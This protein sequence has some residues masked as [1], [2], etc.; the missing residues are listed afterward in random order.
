MGEQQVTPI[1]GNKDLVDG[2]LTIRYGFPDQGEKT[3]TFGPSNVSI[4]I[5]RSGAIR[6]QIPLLVGANDDLKVTAQE[7]QL[8]RGAGMFLIRLDP[9]TMAET[10]ETDLRV[11]ERRVVTLLLRSANSLN[12]RI[13]FGESQ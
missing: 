2:L 8:K 13:S 4:D 7:I 9:Q 1:G 3:L 12:Y 5:Q 11:G 10:I 6:E